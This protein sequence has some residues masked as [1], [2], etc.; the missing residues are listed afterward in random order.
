MRRSIATTDLLVALL[1]VALLQLQRY[2]C[3]RTYRSTR[4]SIVA[5]AAIELLH[6][7]HSLHLSMKG[8]LTWLWYA[9]SATK[10]AG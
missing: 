5:T 8:S 3:Y 4:T 10:K 6:A 7:L 1:S 9:Q 2:G